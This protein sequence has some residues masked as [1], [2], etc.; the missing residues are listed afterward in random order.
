MTDTAQ[1]IRQPRSSIARDFFYTIIFLALVLV[2]VLGVATLHIHFGLELRAAAVVGL[3]YLA[4]LVAGTAIG[5]RSRRVNEL[6]QEIEE[7]QTELKLLRLE[8]MHAPPPGMLRRPGPEAGRPG[9]LTPVPRRGPPRPPMPTP[10]RQPM[11]NGA[12]AAADRELHR[13][14]PPQPTPPR[15]Q[16]DPALTPRDSRP[17]ADEVR[18]H[19]PAPKEPMAQSPRAPEGGLPKPAGPSREMAPVGDNRPPQ[20]AAAPLDIASMQGL[21]EQLAAKLDQPLLPEDGPKARS[22]PSSAGRPAPSPT[23]DVPVTGGIKVTTTPKAE[24]PVEARTQARNWKRACAR[25]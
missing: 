9:N 6:N 24:R 11:P 10:N 12:P 16:A 23:P 20:R 19:A 8:R 22:G 14:P 5:R 15:P 4:V 13:G 2:S 18:D 21:I 7:L 17:G 25:R 3:A 1:P